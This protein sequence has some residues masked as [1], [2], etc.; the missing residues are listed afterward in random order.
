M[1]V[2]YANNGRLAISLRKEEYENPV[3]LMKA[4]RSHPD[5]RGILQAL[6]MAFLAERRVASLANE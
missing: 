3:E 4:F 5:G 6:W 2:L 1:V